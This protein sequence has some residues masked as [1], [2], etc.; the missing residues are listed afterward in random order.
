VQT[1]IGFASGLSAA[2]KQLQA[3]KA[4]IALMSAPS[5]AATLRAEGVDPTH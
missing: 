3:A 4:L 2:T 5:A 1:W